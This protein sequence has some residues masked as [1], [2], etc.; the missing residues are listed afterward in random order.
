MKN[1]IVTICAAFFAWAVI[2]W[3]LIAFRVEPEWFEAINFWRVF[4]GL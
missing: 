1:I 3:L 2:S 4:T